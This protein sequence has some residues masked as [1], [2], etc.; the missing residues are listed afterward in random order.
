MDLRVERLAQVLVE[1][2]ARIGKGD[3]VL[4][5]AEPAAEPLVRALF[6]RILQAGGHPH[7]FISL[8]GMVSYTGLDDLFLRYAS[9]AQ[10]EAEASFYRLAYEQFE[11]RI[12]IHS[13]RNTKALAGVDPARVAQRQA[14]TG[15]V[16]EAQFRRG[17]QGDF[18]WVT[19][20]FPTDALAQEADMSLEEYEDFLYR[21]CHVD[22]PD[23]VAFWQK[24][25]EEQQ[26]IVDAL[27][28]HDRVQIRSPHCDLSLSIKGRTFINASGLHNMPDGEVYTGPVED[29]VEGWVH[30]TFPAVFRG[31]V[32]E[33]VRLVFKAGRVVEATAEKN[34]AFLEKML[35][36]DGGSRYLGEF[37]LGNN[38]GIQCHTRNILFDEKI[39]GTMHL[40]LGA[41]YPETG[42]RNKSAIHWDM[43]CDLRQEA[44][45]LVDGETIFRDGR[46]LI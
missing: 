31:T 24:L 6:R 3:R 45:V 23:P 36:A 10:L 27:H 46:F 19:T 7:L 9:S 16:L 11:A 37:A 14:A 40:A 13:D 42:S 39:G 38:F 30:F 35:D 8:G 1:Y 32:V 17:A 20:Q 41:G 34:Q 4:I 5:E 15:Y 43:I 12:R 28:G 25:S 22:E 26:R 29:S 33:G 18:R 2:S 44:E 21:A